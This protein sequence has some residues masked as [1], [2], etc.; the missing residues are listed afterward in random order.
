[1]LPP[2][3]QRELLLIGG[4]H[5]HVQ[6]LRRQL[7]SPLP[8]VRVTLVADRPL[9]V[10]SGMVPGVIAGQYCRDEAEIDLRPL[11]RRADA[12]CIVAPVV[13]LDL[14]ERRVL[15]ADRPPLRYDQASLNV[16]SQ[17]RAA[18]APGVAEH[19][20]ATRPIGRFVEAADRRFARVGPGPLPVVVVGGGAAGVELAFCLLE[21]AKKCGAKPE[22]TLVDGRERLLSDLPASLLRR[23]EIEAAKRGIRLITGRRVLAVEATAVLLDDGERLPQAL[24]A[25]VTGAA[26]PPWLAA[27]G[28]P[29]D[30]AGFVRVDERLQV[31]GHPELFAVGDCASLPAPVPKAGVYAVR[32]GAV[33]VENLRRWAEGQPL[34]PYTPQR[35]FL[36]L[37]NLGDGTALGSKWGLA[38]GGPRVMQLKD[39]IDRRFMEKFQV[40]DPRG[41]ELEAF[42]R[43]LPPMPELPM[44]CGGCAAKVGEA[45]LTRALRRLPPL[46]DPEVVLG[47]AEGDD[48]SALQRP[49]GLVVATIDA[50]P[51]FCEDPWLIGRVAAVN[52]LSD[53]HAKGVKPRFALAL[54]SI[55]AD[56]D[57]EETLFQVLAGARAA[58]DAEGC[59][60]VG[61]HTTSGDSLLVGFSVTGFTE[62][63]RPRKGAQVGDALILSRPLGTGVLWRADALGRA[64]G[65][66]VEA[67]LSGLVRGNGPASRALEG[68]P[69]HAATDITGFG[70]A[71]HL[72]AMMRDSGLCAALNLEALRGLPGALDLLRSGLRSTF[73]ERN[74]EALRAVDASPEA[75]A[76]PRF[77]LLFD[78]Q[79]SGGLALAVP[80]AA[81]EQVLERLREVEP[82]AAQVGAVEPGRPDGALL[83]VVK[84]AAG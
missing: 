82:E 52:A 73:H 78:P 38:F 58:L 16:G 44:R 26:A 53:M 61:G 80:E 45:A 42:S 17:I 81:L 19:A 12:A 34:R 10:Y 57:E 31:L 76:D 51:A 37:L 15:F 64:R 62:A 7:M 39:R 36:A 8:G 79:T 18:D 22:M 14:A 35:D 41:T 11:A 66:D 21:R 74:R 69:V 2:R 46:V 28:L 40:L 56:R 9:A 77:E 43:D 63:L 25:W 1:M 47:V 60:L 50:F 54:V 59:S 6:V 55:P 27:S 4:G 70:L 68:L 30:E 48:V 13:G 49:E 32:E 67:M 5:A 33:L 72:G 29:A 75:A 3:P 23:V 83:R 71:G 84:G 65:P 24:C 20:L